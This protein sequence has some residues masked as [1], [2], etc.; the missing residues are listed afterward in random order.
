MKLI[1]CGQTTEIRTCLF[2]KNTVFGPTTC[3]CT[4]SYIDLYK[5]AFEL[6]TVLLCQDRSCG[7]KGVCNKERVPL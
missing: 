4:C 1:C 5:T 7:P 3:T 6:R 2:N